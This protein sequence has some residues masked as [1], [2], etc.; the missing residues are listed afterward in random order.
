[1]SL[2]LAFLAVAAFAD[3]VVLEKIYKPLLSQYRIPWNQVEL[4]FWGVKCLWWH[5]A[6]VVMILSFYVLLGIALKDWRLPMAGM[7]LFLLG[8][9]DIFY[10]LLQ[11][12]WLPTELPWLDY[13][14]LLTLSRWLTGTDHVTATGVAIFALLGMIS[15][16][17]L[18]GIYPSSRQRF[19]SHVNQTP[20]S[21]KREYGEI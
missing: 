3:W 13:S 21:D 6:L 16:L 17:L 12:Q 19:L 8:V 2:I 20:D 18:L 15:A 5:I 14:P 9:E 7:T 4:N 1:M 10:Y 11:C